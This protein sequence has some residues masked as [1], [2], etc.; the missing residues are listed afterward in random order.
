VRR[1]QK[2]PTQHAVDESK[3]LRGRIAE[4]ERLV[5]KQQ[6]AIVFF[7]RA[8]AHIEGLYPPGTAPGGM[9]STK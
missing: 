3:Q 7:K 9:G 1:P 2:E 5:G 6:L 8:F 4:L